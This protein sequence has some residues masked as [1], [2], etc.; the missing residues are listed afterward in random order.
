MPAP[1]LSESERAGWGLSWLIYLGERWWC[2]AVLLLPT[3]FSSEARKPQPSMR[4]RQACGVSSWVVCSL[5][6]WQAESQL[7]PL[8]LLRSLFSIGAVLCRPC[9]D[10][11]VF[12]SC[13][14][15]CC[16]GD[17]HASCTSGLGQLGKSFT[18][19]FA[20]S[21]WFLYGVDVAPEASLGPTKL[22]GGP[23]C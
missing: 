12:A 2:V 1:Q 9:H 15:Q 17:T 23:K 13:S 21:Q 18:G 5:W 20:E 19:C 4:A 14:L 6:P 8:W 11:R 22:W 10:P 16:H 3:L 7:C